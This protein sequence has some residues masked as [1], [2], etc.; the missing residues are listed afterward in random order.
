M[1]Q[2]KDIRQKITYAD[3]I[4]ELEKGGE[5]LVNPTEYIIE[6]VQAGEDI[7]RMRNGCFLAMSRK[8]SVNQR[9]TISGKN[10]YILFFQNHCYFC[11][12]RKT[13]PF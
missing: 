3:N 4:E 1:S 9:I 5:L 8:L 7:I 6:E 2:R 11:Q 10:E 13:L 12:Y